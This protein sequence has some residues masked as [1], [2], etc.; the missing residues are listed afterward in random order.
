MTSSRTK[1]TSTVDAGNLLVITHPKKFITDHVHLHT[2]KLCTF[3]LHL[4]I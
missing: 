3:A 2:E 1:N 4:L